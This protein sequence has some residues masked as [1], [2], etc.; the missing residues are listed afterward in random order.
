MKWTIDPNHTSLTFSIGYFGISLV[1][2]SFRTL[3]GAAETNESG[4]LTAVTLRID[5]ASIDT[6]QSQRDAALRS[7]HFFDAANHPFILVDATSR[8]SSIAAVIEMRGIRVPV[9]FASPLVSRPILDPEGRRRIGGSA[10]ATIDRTV[11]GVSGNMPLPS[12]A[13]AIALE[14]NVRLDAEAIADS[15]EGSA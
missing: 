5:S 3:A 15:L 12:G 7:E 14:L 10:T 1:N 11:W 9:E 2:G 13:P 8:G 4:A 6:N